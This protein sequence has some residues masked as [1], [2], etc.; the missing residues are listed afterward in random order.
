LESAVSPGL[1][2]GF[3]FPGLQNGFVF[4]GLQTGLYFFNCFE[5]FKVCVIFDWLKL[6]QESSE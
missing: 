4:T 2:K 3:V 6:L 1:Q 5:E